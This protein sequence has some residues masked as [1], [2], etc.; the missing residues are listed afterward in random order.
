MGCR[1]VA[2][3]EGWGLTSWQPVDEVSLFQSRS[4]KLKRVTDL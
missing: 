1:A 2:E 4:L 3:V